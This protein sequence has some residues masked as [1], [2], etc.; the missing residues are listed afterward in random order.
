MNHKNPYYFLFSARAKT[1]FSLVFVLP[2]IIFAHPDYDLDEFDDLGLDPL[3]N[4]NNNPIRKNNVKKKVI[5]FDDNLYL[6]DDEFNLG[7][8]EYELQKLELNPNDMDTAK[9]YEEFLNAFFNNSTSV[10]ANP[11]INSTTSK[12]I[13]S[14]KSNTTNHKAKSS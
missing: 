8:D 9:D 3:N 1:F 10:G 2:V 7:D 13:K 11:S 14:K 5:L 12:T 4:S 6:L